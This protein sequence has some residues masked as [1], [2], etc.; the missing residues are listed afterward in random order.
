MKQN[1][2]KR[3]KK[4]RE[5]RLQALIERKRGEK[6]AA[7]LQQEQN[8]KRQIQQYQEQVE[9]LSMGAVFCIKN[10]SGEDVN[11]RL[12]LKM[13]S[14]GKLLFVDSSGIKIKELLPQEVALELYQ[15]T[16]T[17]LNDVKKNSSTLE[18]LVA[19]QRNVLNKR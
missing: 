17:L 15:G 4:S 6:R 14:S 12:A 9:S 5:E 16:M 13:R 2:L 10:G 7:K 11:A 1:V 3:L 19:H 8:K 18:N